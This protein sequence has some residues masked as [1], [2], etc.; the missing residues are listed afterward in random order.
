MERSAEVTHS[1]FLLHGPMHFSISQRRWGF[2]EQRFRS[3]GSQGFLV[4]A[5]FKRPILGADS[6][7]YLKRPTQI[8]PRRPLFYV[9]RIGVIYQ[10][11]NDYLPEICKAVFDGIGITYCCRSGALSLATGRL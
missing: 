8:C 1:A 4:G 10:N 2:A 7:P 11:S 5:Q 9:R 6:I 3:L